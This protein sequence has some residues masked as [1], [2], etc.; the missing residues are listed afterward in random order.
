MNSESEVNQGKA[1]LL[2]WG[3]TSLRP[4][5]KLLILAI[6]DDCSSN[7]TFFPDC[8]SLACVTGLSPGEVGELLGLFASKGVI[9]GFINALD[10]RVYRL[11][12]EHL[13]NLSGLDSNS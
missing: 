7:G 12:L 13:D 3:A 6:A 4:K 1:R 8:L 5:V 11:H 2:I 10:G 9:Q